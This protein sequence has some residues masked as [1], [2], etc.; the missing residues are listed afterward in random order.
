MAKNLQL[1][2]GN[3][4][5]LG[6][7]SLLAGEPIFTLDTKKLYIGDGTNKVLI[8]PDQSTNALT[9]DKLSTARTI[10]LAGGVTGSVSF[11]GSSDVTINT[12][13][14]LT[15]SDIPSLTMA[16]ITDA[17][18]AASKNVGTAAGNIPVLD[19][20]GK[21]TSSVLPAIAITDT[22]IVA[23]EAEMLALTAQTGDVAIRTD[24]SKSFI[25]KGTDPSVL[26]DWAEL[27][28]PTGGDVQSVNGKTGSVTLTATDVGLGNVTNESKT[29]MFT[30]A[31]LTGAPTAPTATVDDSSTQIATTA[32]VKS[33][34]YL[35]GS[36]S[37]DF[38][39]F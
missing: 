19:A 17:G 28:S 25:L 21:L 12:S 38:G 33:Q 26:S 23:T 34:G 3:S 8:N 9:A 16:K 15:A 36:D 6:S 35:T 14:N 22:F 5:N 7:L 1:K 11:D 30:D 18:T 32:F 13:A 39:T 20:S 10:T 31:A 4:S 37:M 24:L 29:T 2:R 27:L